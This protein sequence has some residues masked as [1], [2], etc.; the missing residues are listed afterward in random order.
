MRLAHVHRTS[1]VRS[2]NGAQVPPYTRGSVSLSLSLALTGTRGP[3]VKAW[4]FLI[5]T[6]ASPSRAL[7]LSQTH[8]TV[9]TLISFVHVS[10]SVHVLA[11]SYLLIRSCPLIRPSQSISKFLSLLRLSSSRV[12]ILS[13]DFQHSVSHSTL[14][15]PSDID[16][17][18]PKVTRRFLDFVI[19]I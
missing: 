15:F 17:L 5:H 3:N 9:R 8:S 16:G 12:S 4:C 7:S 6:E 10:C 13:V 1:M 2:T 19:C 18:R 11:C 14:K